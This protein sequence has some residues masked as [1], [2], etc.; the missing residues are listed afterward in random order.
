M[1]RVA[2]T[3]T[4][5]QARIDSQSVRSAGT[6]NLLRSVAAG[7]SGL[8]RDRH[9]VSK[10]GVTPFIRQDGTHPAAGHLFGGLAILKTLVADAGDQGRSSNS[11]ACKSFAIQAPNEPLSICSPAETLGRGAW[12]QPRPKA[13]QNCVSPQFASRPG[14]PEE[15]SQFVRRNA[16]TFDFNVNRPPHQ[17]CACVTAPMSA[18]VTASVAAH[19]PT[20]RRRLCHTR[21][22]KRF[23]RRGSLSHATRPP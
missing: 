11:R 20:R 7:P 17:Q 16:P 2:N 6:G 10:T 22:A 5:K 8:A 13:R 21:D 14:D 19:L 1:W 12:A 23:T 9:P 18:F 3:R 15:E 4:A